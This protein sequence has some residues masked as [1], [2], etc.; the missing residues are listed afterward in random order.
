MINIDLTAHNWQ[1]WKRTCLTCHCHEIDRKEAVGLKSSNH[2]FKK[3]WFFVKYVKFGA[4]FWKELV[5]C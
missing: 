5:F 2:T 3:S 4:I 1:K